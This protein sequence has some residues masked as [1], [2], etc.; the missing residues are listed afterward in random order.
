MK[1]KNK[2]VTVDG[3]WEQGFRLK[4]TKLNCMISNDHIGKTLSVSDGYT[5]FH[6][7]FEQ[8]EPYLK[9]DYRDTE[10]EDKR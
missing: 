5:T 8:I 9:G 2:F 3:I 1:C 7:A 10:Q 4:R 6:I